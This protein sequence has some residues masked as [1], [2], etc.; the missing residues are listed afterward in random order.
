MGGLNFDNQMSL[1]HFLMDTLQDTDKN[2]LMIRSHLYKFDNKQR[3]KL[4]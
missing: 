4:N 1:I 2:V 3:F